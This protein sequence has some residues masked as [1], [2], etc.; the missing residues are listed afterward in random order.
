MKDSDGGGSGGSCPPCQTG[1]YPNCVPDSSQDGNNC[2]AC[3]QCSSGLC[4]PDLNRS[5]PTCKQCGAGGVCENQENNTACGSNEVCCGGTCTTGTS[6]GPCPDGPDGHQCPPDINNEQICCYGT[7]NPCCADDQG[8]AMCGATNGVCC[9]VGTQIQCGPNCCDAA[10]EQCGY[11]GDVST[12]TCCPT[13]QVVVSDGTCCDEARYCITES[14]T[15]CCPSGQ[16]CATDPEQTVSICCDTA[17]ADADG[18]CCAESFVY[19]YCADQSY[20]CCTSGDDDACCA[21]HGGA[22]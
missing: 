20:I 8:N 12:G 21:N 3:G 9:T 4:V 2:N 1:T 6:C 13:G 15:I 11:H 14:G 19:A 16:Q 18:Q 17:Y 22:A 5:C 7:D 10:T